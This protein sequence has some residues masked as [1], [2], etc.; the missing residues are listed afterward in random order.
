[1]L[2]VPLQLWL[3][4][5]PERRLLVVSSDWALVLRRPQR[6]PTQ[7]ANADT[8]TDESIVIELLPRQDVDLERATLLHSRVHGCLGVLA[9]AGDVFLPV[10]THAT[11]LG[12]TYNRPL[13][14]LGAEP[15][16]RILSVDFFC[17]SSSAF[18]Y[19][20]A[21]VTA[22]DA[23]A[24]NGG[25]GTYRDST[26]SFDISPSASSANLAAASAARTELS[27]PPPTAIEHPCQAIRKI[28]SNSNFYFSSGPDA[29]DLS[30]RLQA[31]LE[32][33]GRKKAGDEGEDEAG[34][35]LRTGGGSRTDG[36]EEAQLD[37]D[38]RFLWNTYLVGPLLSFRTSLSPELRSV[39]DD[40]GFMVLAIQGY[41]GTYDI[42]LGGEPVVLSLI[43]R[44]G[45]KR[46]GTRFNVRGVDDDGSVAN[47]VETETI[48]RTKDLCFSYVQT[49]G[50]VPLF[51]EE[52]GSQPFNQKIAVTRPIE[53]SLPAFLR[54]CEDLFDHYARFHVLN[55]LANKEGEAILTMAYEAHLRAAQ[56]ADENVRLNVGMTAFDFHAR[57]R[58]GGGI[59]SVQAQLWR[60]LESVEETIGACV[61]G[62]DGHGEVA[63][64][65]TQ[66]GVFRTNCKAD[67]PSLRQCLD[68]TN[69][70]EDCLSRFALE[71]FLKNIRPEWL[72]VL[73]SAS[74]WG[75]HRTLWADN[76]DAL[77]KIYVGTGALNTSFTR[78]GKKSLAGL[79]SDASKSV[80]RVFQ[81][82]LFDS[83]KQKAIDALLFNL[84]PKGNLATSRRVRIFNPIHDVLRAELRERED[85]FT[86]YSTETIWVGTWNVNGRPPSD[87]SLLPWL[88]PTEGPE[89]SLLVLGFQEIVPLSPQQIM[90]TDPEKKRRWE[91][92][93]LDAVA[94]RPGKKT[95]Y[96]LLRSGQLVGTALI[97]LC[98][99]EVAAQVRN[100]EA[101][102]K[103][104]AV[105]IRLDYRATSFC[106][107]TA[108][109]AAGHSNIME[110]EQDYGTIA[111]G[112]HFS[113]G[114]AI[115]DHEHVIW[116]ADTNFRIGLSNDEV[117]SL[118]ERDEYDALWAADQL[119]KSM[120]L[121]RSYA[122]YTEA[123]VVFRPT[124]KYDN[125]T[126]DYDSS[127]KQ[128]IPAYTDRILYQV[129][130]LFRSRIRQVDTARRAA[131]RKQL[132]QQLLA[133]T[134]S[135][136]LDLRLDRL[137][138]R[139]QNKPRS[140]LPPPSDD[141]Q[142]WWNEKDGSFK[143]P[144][145]PPRPRAALGENP[146]DGT[147]SSPPS[148]AGRDGPPAPDATSNG[149][150]PVP[151]LPSRA[152][153]ATPGPAINA[154]SEGSL[155]DVSEE[156]D[157]SAAPS[158][159]PLS[160][161]A[162]KRQAP[163]VPPNRTSSPASTKGRPGEEDVDSE[164]VQM[165]AYGAPPPP[166]RLNS[167]GT[168]ESWQMLP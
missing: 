6:T 57:S 80:N 104:G 68:R 155:I 12:S 41:V 92:H 34:A 160:F 14:G 39:F 129:Y 52:G 48:L 13:T 143:P 43:S 9:V 18:D 38:S 24:A 103:K 31:R 74:L 137:S 81:Q 77:S 145:L 1:M 100:V 22:A 134:F 75:S 36:Y 44:L 144:P 113:R 56:D 7:T 164:Q 19:L 124:Y 163:P 86:S 91:Q 136:T 47:F 125:G 141:Q 138:I 120:T 108:H 27:A 123:P 73:E 23:Y 82:Q 106:F 49:R 40:Q 4:R 90:A 66:N 32:K 156:A 140:S 17:L 83:G 150:R 5:K 87:E 76:G 139:R 84:F 29:F 11:E 142:A 128:R 51:W 114:K 10:I 111:A 53:A 162:K 94:N 78:T 115:S 154:T 121:G 161:Q 165:S 54:H 60:E 109:L 135:E 8:D 20:H 72:G 112:L 25:P 67:G 69:A 33:A 96:V 63:R 62:V 110:R 30:T 58:D 107:L 97:I 151:A 50:S 146:F 118:A 79:F 153:Q 71:S 157:P 55:L 148:A 122:G 167:T 21:P 130:A 46:S 117:R 45:W 158:A 119:N 133:D 15:I 102:T 168:G 166:E 2:E 59:E 93:I 70:V 16:N 64:V 61:V 105:A 35:G 147:R 126:D 159:V 131:L 42:T 101:A 28:L 3:V 89:P 116:A 127:E 95:D 65:M 37:H 99:K 85:E 152:P 98:K 88:F 132:L 26:E 149:R